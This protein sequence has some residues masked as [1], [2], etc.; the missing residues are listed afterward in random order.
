M[1]PAG[2]RV[3][4][5]WKA[6]IHPREIL[7]SFCLSSLPLLLCFSPSKVPL[8]SNI[9]VNGGSFTSEAWA[10][11]ERWLDRDTEQGTAVDWQGGSSGVYR[12]KT[13][14][15]GGQDVGTI[16]LILYNCRVHNWWNVVMQWYTPD[17]GDW[18]AEL[19]NKRKVAAHT[20]MWEWHMENL[21]EYYRKDEVKALSK[22][23]GNHSYIRKNFTCINWRE[24]SKSSTGYILMRKNFIPIIRLIILWTTYGLCSLCRN[25]FNSAI[26]FFFTAGNLWIH[27]G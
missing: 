20:F 11:R 18:G 17:I 13:L 27:I 24:A 26:N 4:V 16:Q 5:W 14:L 23:S 8:P 2:S 21:L 7:S 6:T 3:K 9:Y 1:N 10:A 19:Q 12:T 25:S 15:V 22:R